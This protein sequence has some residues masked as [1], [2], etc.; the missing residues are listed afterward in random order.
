MSSPYHICTPIQ[1]DEL[2]IQNGEGVLRSSEEDEEQFQDFEW[3][4]ENYCPTSV[5]AHHILL[6]CMQL[7]QVVLAVCQERA[8]LSRERTEQTILMKEH[9]CQADFTDEDV[10]ALSE[11]SVLVIRVV[12]CFKDRIDTSNA[13][14]PCCNVPS[15]LPTPPPPTFNILARKPRCMPVMQY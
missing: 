7:E 2:C 9:G 4:V 14:A 6:C 3:V 1:D 8:R 11:H 10:L 15:P 12:V 5:H 13:N